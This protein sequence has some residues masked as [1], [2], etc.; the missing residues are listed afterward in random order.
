MILILYKAFHTIDVD[1]GSCCRRSIPQ[2]F[3]EFIKEYAAY[4][5]GNDT[6]KYFT[7]KS[8][9]TQ[10]AQCVKRLVGT[11][12]EAKAET[13]EIGKVLD[14]SADAIADK[15]VCEECK[16][17]E[18]I[19]G[20]GKR[21]KKGSLVQ[22]FLRTEEGEYLYIIAKVEHTE[23]F[24]GISLRRSFG[25]PRE[26]KSV[27][28]SAVFSLN[29]E[30]PISFGVVRIYTDNDAKYWAADFLELAEQRTDAY[31][32]LTAYLAVDRELKRLMKDKSKRDYWLLNNTVYQAMRSSRRI[33]YPNMINDLL[34]SYQPENR[35]LNMDKL[36]KRLLELP[37]KKNF[38]SQFDS[39]PEALAR[40]RQFRFPVT[41]GVELR[42]EESI[43]DKEIEAF[44]DENGNRF[45]RIKCDDNS[46]YQAISTKQRAFVS[47][48]R[49]RR[50]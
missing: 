3:S 50:S 40:K 41:N 31:N 9:A 26:K 5:V 11:V 18:K 22:A 7:V 44:S 12:I 43:E 16:A 32:T 35:E 19:K 6:V 37:E 36:R 27:W 23:F 42:I 4:A 48:S 15:L 28:K 2:D 1:S 21:I 13:E 45:I 38:D 17:Q 49:G 39:V 14:A 10:A 29:V 46:T 30:Q 8:E 47:Q 33:D 25:F 20:M 24:D 34:E